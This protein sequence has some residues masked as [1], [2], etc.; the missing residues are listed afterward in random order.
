MLDKAG[1]LE[2]SKVPSELHSKLTYTVTSPSCKVLRAD[3]E[4]V[5]EFLAQQAK[6]AKEKMIDA[7]LSKTLPLYS[8][9]SN[10]VRHQLLLE[11]ELVEYNPFV[12]I[13]TEGQTI[14]HAFLIMEGECRLTKKVQ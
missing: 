11:F 4:E 7:F 8:N 14:S 6:D 9:S 12:T 2:A 13:L 3:N 1:Y 10:K 5:R